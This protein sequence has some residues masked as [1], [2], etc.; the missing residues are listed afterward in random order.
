MKRNFGRMKRV[1]AAIAAA[2]FTM[3]LRGIPAMA[4][5]TTYKPVSGGKAVFEKYLTMRTQANV[6]NT[7]FNYTVSGAV[8][9]LDSDGTTTLKVYA[10]N[11]S[12]KVTGTPTITNAVFKPGDATYSEVQDQP[13][14]VTVQNKDNATA[15]NKDSVT[16]ESGKKYARHDVTVDF[17]G[18]TYNEP[19]VYRYVI[20]ES[21]NSDNA[22]HGIVNDTD[23]T[24]VMD[25]Y[26]IDKDGALQVQGYVLQNGEPDGTLL[27]D[28]TGTADKSKGYANDYVTND[29][30]LAKKVEGNQASRD[31]YFKLT[32]KIDN[33]VPGTVYD[34]DLTNADATTKTNGDNRQTYENPAKLTVGDDGTVTQ[35]YWLQGGQSIKVQGVAL[36]SG[37]SVNEDADTLDKDSYDPS[38]VITG[39]TKNGSNTTDPDVSM[40]ATNYTVKD[41][42]LTADT[43]VT[44]TNTKAGTIPTG[45]IMSVVPGAVVCIGAAAAVVVMMNK[46]K[47]S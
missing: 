3:S 1:E 47:E 2:A 13:D 12:D 16:L 21:A 32:L 20:N 18:V 22:A 6:P 15:V 46:K 29:L 17:S 43:T 7:T 11:D 30:T 33:A 41:S 28:G 9:S 24:R 38:A 42:A 40:D 39:D 19:G 44:Y 23:A 14:S 4:E 26:V 35:E 36:N 27:R 25:V 5:G 37:Y 10:G 45:V 34:V 31:R 8:S